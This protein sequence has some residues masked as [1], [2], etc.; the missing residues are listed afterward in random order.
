MPRVMVE[1]PCWFYGPDGHEEIFNSRA[2]VPSG[3]TKLKPRVFEPVDPLNVDEDSVRLELEKLGVV[4]DPTWGKAHLKKVL[5]DRS[6][7]R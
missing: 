1:W 2:E 7:P 3:W 5:D 4:I 6:P